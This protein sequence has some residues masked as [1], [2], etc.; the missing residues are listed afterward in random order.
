VTIR[1]SRSVALGAALLAGAV[2]AM[3]WLGWRGAAGSDGEAPW[4]EPPLFHPETGIERA[5]AVDVASESTLDLTGEGQEGER[6]SFSLEAHGV[7]ALRAYAGPGEG[8]DV[9]ARLVQ[10]QVTVNGQRPSFAEKL[11][12]P[13]SFHMDRQGR[14]TAIAFPPG[15]PEEAS[16]VL[17]QILIRLQV[18]LPRHR[19][20]TWRTRERDALGIFRAAYTVSPRAP[21]SIEKRKLQYVPADGESLQAE[22]VDSRAMF[23][24]EPGSRGVL[25]VTGAEILRRRTGYARGKES[26]RFQFRL[27]EAPPTLPGSFLE[28]AR[29]REAAG[30][31]L[32]RSSA[33]PPRSAGVASGVRSA[34]DALGRFHSLFQK[35]RNAAEGLVAAW[36]RRQPGAPSDLVRS[37]DAMGRDPA[38]APL[39]AAERSV[40]WRL[41]AQTGTAEAEGA[42]LDAAIDPT[43][44]VL[45][46]R[47]A[48]MHFSQVLVARP[49]MVDGLL[50]LCDAGDQAAGPEASG[51]GSMAL[52]AV[53]ALGHRDLATPELTRSVS[54]ALQERLA[55]AT[56]DARLEVLTAMANVG[57][58]S[59]VPVLTAE[60]VDPDPSLRAAAVE[61]FRRMEPAEAQP[62]LLAHAAGE[63]DPAVRARTIEML[64]QSRPDR[65]VIAWASAEVARE[66][67]ARVLLPLIDLLGSSCDRSPEARQALQRILRTSGEPSV[68]MRVL[69]HVPPAVSMSGGN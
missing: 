34:D 53:G 39:G 18:V 50:A 43:H 23:E 32:A 54:D 26:L 2:L 33:D 46:R 15:L 38:R 8:F 69:R 52:L 12:L 48:I 1:W 24:L 14:F 41:L 58:P 5:Y 17:R 62:V 28:L 55:R 31:P 66:R 6:G 67:D 42:L 60:L 64:R 13:F 68:K 7:L 20:T 65:D 22:V 19:Q 35:D 29:M 45:T 25:Q 40:L 27:T 10:P 36:L 57:D 21:L 4:P 49:S 9:G 56:G 44:P 51:L 61:A 59:L 47:Q 3:G 63:T 16:A 30:I 11:D 37:L